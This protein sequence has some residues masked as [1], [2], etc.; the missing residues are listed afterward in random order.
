MHILDRSLLDKLGIELTD[1][2]YSVLGEYY[3]NTLHERV[4]TEVLAELSDRQVHELSLLKGR[5]D[6]LINEW[7]LKNVT[8]IKDIVVDEV[9]ILLGEIVKGSQ[10]P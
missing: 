6:A 10:L 5:E 2:E 9:N 8:N 7:L 4:I 1:N 3:S